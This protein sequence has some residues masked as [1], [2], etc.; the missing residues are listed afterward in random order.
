MSKKKSGK[1]KLKSSFLT[2]AQWEGSN[3]TISIG[4]KNYDFDRVPQKIIKGLKEAKSPGTF[5]NRKIKGRYQKPY[6]LN[7]P[8]G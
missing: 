8:N 3:L 7:T 6:K 2:E 4:E 5:F 1:V